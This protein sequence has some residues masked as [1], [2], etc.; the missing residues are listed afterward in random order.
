MF[1]SL[2]RVFASMALLAWRSGRSKDLEII[3][4]RHQLAVL[5]R[6]IDRPNLSAD[7]RALLGVIAQA[8]PR[9]RRA[10]WLVTPDMLL[11]WHRRP[12]ARHW[13]HPSRSPGRPSAAVEL[14]RLVLRMATENPTSGYRPIHG[15]STANTGRQGFR[16]TL[17]WESA[18]RASRPHHHLEP[19][20]TRTTCN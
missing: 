17:D 1:R 3:V 15:Q 8:M 4:L 11:G 10:G 14:G 18:P 5:R 20:P 13:T 19:P 7:D 12:N 9:S 16:G 6:Q 2:Y